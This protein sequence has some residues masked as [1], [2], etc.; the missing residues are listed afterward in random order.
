MTWYQNPA[1][2]IAVGMVALQLTLTWFRSGETDKEVKALRAHYDALIAALRMDVDS[3]RE[4]RA[5]AREKFTNLER[6]TADEDE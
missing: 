6:R 3:L 4:W 2:W 5:Q 1:L